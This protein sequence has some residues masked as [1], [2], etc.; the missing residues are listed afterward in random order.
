ME[1]MMEEVEGTG[2]AWA[3][4]RRRNVEFRMLFRVLATLARD[5]EVVAGW[6]REREMRRRSSLLLPLTQLVVILVTA[7]TTQDTLQH[8][9]YT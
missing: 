7:E 3:L 6:K 9:T 8:P 5:L 4:W 2:R 1:G